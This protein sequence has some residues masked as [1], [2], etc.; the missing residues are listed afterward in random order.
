MLMR[1]GTEEQKALFLPAIIRGD[2]T[3][4]IGY[5]EAQGGTDLGAITTRAVSEPSTGDYL[6]NGSKLFT[7]GAEDAD[8]IWLACRTS[9][10]LP[11]HHGVSV[12][13]VSTSAPG[14]SATTVHTVADFDTAITYYEDVRVPLESRIGEE[15]AGWQIITG[16]LNHE[17]VSLAALSARADRLFEEV[18]AWARCQTATSGA[19]LI[20]QSWV[21]L[22]LA[23]VRA[24]LDAMWLMSWRLADHVAHGLLGGAEASVV[25]VFSSEGL[26]EVYRLLLEVLGVDGYRR[27]EAPRAVLHGEV[28]AVSRQAQLLTFTAGV[29][30]VQRELIARLGLGMPRVPR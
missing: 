1:Y 4:A 16:Q 14:F 7:S 23:Q 30:E 19:S 2:I 20:G 10:D 29:N 13:L 11:R 6:I 25:K 5:S 28:E 21:Q 8:W 15:N 12:F 3:F 9:N 24:R 17:R 26:V 27:S 18:V 22:N